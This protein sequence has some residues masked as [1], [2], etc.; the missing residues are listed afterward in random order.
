MRLFSAVLALVVVS[1]S[2]IPVSKAIAADSIAAGIC[3]EVQ[4]DSKMR[5]RKQLKEHRMK[6]RNVYNDIACNGESLLRFAYHSN[7]NDAGKFI[8]KRLLTDQLQATESDGKSIA[9][10]ASANG[11]A[12][13]PITK[14]INS[15]LGR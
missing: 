1:S 6:L 4:A 10:W 8:A 7:A 5:L 11:F 13:S 2:I 14:A 3:T 9:D 15:R 12:D